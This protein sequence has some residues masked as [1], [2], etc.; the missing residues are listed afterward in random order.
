MRPG[1]GFYILI[2]N[3]DVF[4]SGGGLSWGDRGL[5]LI[6]DGRALEWREM[7]E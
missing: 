5:N 1:G 4:L 3:F 7:D 2:S 6:N